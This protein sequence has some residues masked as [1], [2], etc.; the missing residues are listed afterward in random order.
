MIINYKKL[1]CSAVK[2]LE[3]FHK[4]RIEMYENQKDLITGTEQ[5]LIELILKVLK[6]SGLNDSEKQI[7]CFKIGVNLPELMNTFM[8][9]VKINHSISYYE[10]LLN[11]IL[12]N[13]LEKQRQ[14]EKL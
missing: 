10:K 11:N 1:G 13:I 2:V 14:E 6:E 5:E 4:I 8:D 3:T 7:L 9:V 12:N